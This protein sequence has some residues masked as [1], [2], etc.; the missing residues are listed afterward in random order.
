MA[1]RH[2]DS[3][4]K[5]EKLPGFARAISRKKRQRQR[6]AAHRA[7]ERSDGIPSIARKANMGAGLI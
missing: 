1:K 7:F 6:A 4:V 3:I 5:N 2:F